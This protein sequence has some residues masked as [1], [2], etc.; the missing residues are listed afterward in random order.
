MQF[1]M[2]V[3]RYDLGEEWVLYENLLATWAAFFCQR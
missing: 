3:L 1:K 2:S